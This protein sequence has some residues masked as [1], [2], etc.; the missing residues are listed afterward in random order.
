MCRTWNV[1][2]FDLKSR[3]ITF[4]KVVFRRKSR[5]VDSTAAL[6]AIIHCQGNIFFCIGTE[7]SYV[8]VVCVKK[9]WNVNYINPRSHPADV[10][11]C[12]SFKVISNDGI[13]FSV[14]QPRT[15][16]TIRLPHIRKLYFAAVLDSY[17]SPLSTK[18]ILTITNNFQHQV[19]QQIWRRAL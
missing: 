16:I 4:P 10:S 14:P 9:N 12:G 19:L 1:A 5:R 2:T 18:W 11:E 15:N 8:V 13:F 6:R 7:K 3:N 17:G